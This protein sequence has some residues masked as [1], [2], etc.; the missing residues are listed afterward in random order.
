M[1][2]RF[3]CA[4]EAERNSMSKSFTICSQCLAHFGQVARTATSD[5]TLAAV[6]H[7]LSGNNF[8]DPSNHLAPDI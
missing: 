2:K 5:V 1:L 7:R 6:L 4:E 8:A 3:A